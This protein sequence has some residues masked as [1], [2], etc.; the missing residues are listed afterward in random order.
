MQIIHLVDDFLF[1]IFPELKGGGNQDVINTLEKYYTYG[2]YKPKV[3]IED[4]YVK[5]EIDIPTITSQEADYRKV[6]SLCEKGN[7]P[8]AKPI[9][10]DL[11]EKNPTNSEYHRIMGQILSDEG[12]QDEAIDCLIDALRWDSRNEFALIMMGNIFAKFKNDF[13]TAFKYFEQALTVNPHNNIA[14]NHIGAGL[15]QQGKIDEAKEYLHKALT[16]N[17]DYPNTHFALGLIAE[18]ENDLQ[19]AF[20]SYNTAIKLN[21]NK[22]VLYENS[23]RKI[24]DIAKKIVLTEVGNKI[25]TEYK[26]KLEFKGEIEIDIIEDNSIT[27]AAKM[28]FAENY[29]RDKHIIKYKSNYPAVEHLIMHELVHLDFVIDARKANLNQVFI[30]TQKQKS[31]F[32]KK[33]ESSIAKFRKMGINDDA[34]ADFCSGIF[35]GLNLQVYNTPIDLFIENYLYNQYTA[36]RPF[37]FLSQYTLIQEG[38][39]A[40]TDKKILE[41]SPKDVLSK[42]KIYNLVNALQFGELYAIDIIKDFKATVAELKTATDF[43]EEYLQYKDDKEPAEEYELVLN[44]AEDLKLD[45]NFELVNENEYRNKRT[46]LDNLVSSIEKDPY[47]LETIDP[48]KEREMSKFQ[49]SQDKIGTNMAVVMYMVDALKYFEG[50]KKEEIKAIAFEIA[51]LGIHGFH[52]EMDGYKIHLIPDKDFSGY[53]ILA[54]YYVSW[55]LAI[56]ESVKE[57]NL[58][59]DNEYQLAITMYNPK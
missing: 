13:P 8:N 26:H 27:T 36:L 6:V 7:Y 47:D 49:K 18:K 41:L 32:I 55:M 39:K 29:K 37:Q 12:N 9:L 21:P 10:A 50:M 4:N 23:I 51:T 52:P 31:E 40:V 14:I 43:Y 38:I 24:F 1:T 59:F 5:V 25:L 16:I 15:L 2:P 42:S 30:S 35:N 28:E 34:I 53:H 57:L 44:W 33:L 22:D 54:F 56:P 3:T 20:S 58:H 48:Y 11:I 45:M 19:A 46:N 17:N